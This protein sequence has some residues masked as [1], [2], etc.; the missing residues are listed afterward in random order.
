MADPGN[1]EPEFIQVRDVKVHLLRVGRGAALLYLH[2]EER[3]G[4]REPFVARLARDFDVIA[5]DHPGFGQTE[6]PDWLDRIDDMIYHYVDLLDHLGLEKVN[7][8]GESFGGWLAAELAVAHPERIA[9]LALVA[10]AGLDLTEA[11][12]TDLFAIAPDELPDYL[13]ADPQRAAEG[14]DSN[15]SVEVEQERHRGRFTLAH[16]AWNPLLCNP[17]LRR[18]LY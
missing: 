18:R 1:Q 3:T 12:I 2:G 8:V 14:A 16:L 15:P 11:P 6:R 10:A 9:R 5:P 13:F 17:A 7:V 4:V